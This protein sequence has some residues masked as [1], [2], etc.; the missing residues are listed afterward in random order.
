M[1]RPGGIGGNVDKGSKFAQIKHLKRR[2]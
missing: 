2:K 1:I